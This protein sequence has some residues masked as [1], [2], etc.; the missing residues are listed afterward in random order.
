M[1]FQRILLLSWTY[2]LI[3]LAAHRKLMWSSTRLPGYL[4]P[5]SSMLFCT[6]LSAFK[7][8]KEDVDLR[9]KTW[10]ERVDCIGENLSSWKQNSNFIKKPYCPVGLWTRTGTLRDLLRARKMGQAQLPHDC[11]AGWASFTNNELAGT[12][13]T[14][15]LTWPKGRRWQFWWEE[16]QF[17]LPAHP[18]EALRGRHSLPGN[19]SDK[20][21]WQVSPRD[22]VR[23]IVQINLYCFDYFLVLCVSVQATE[24]NENC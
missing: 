1:I 4:K 5:F 6:G 19:Q 10:Q 9:T 17:T 13:E 15:I 8:T 14:E 3:Y 21:T 23:R 16:K 22:A 2:P 24:K 12:V 20:G 18:V 7:E 11:V